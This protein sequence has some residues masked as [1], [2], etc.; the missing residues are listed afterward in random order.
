MVSKTDLHWIIGNTSYVIR[1]VPYEQIHDEE[2]F[3]M[4]TAIKITMLRDLMV[5]DKIPHDVDFESVVDF[6][7]S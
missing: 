4:N 5:E 6:E 2:S 3:D 1:N 7:F